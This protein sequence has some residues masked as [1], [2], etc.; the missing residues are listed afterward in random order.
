MQLVKLQI[1]NIYRRL[2]QI[3]ATGISEQ[4]SVKS[5]WSENAIQSQPGMEKPGRCVMQDNC[6][7][8]ITV[9]T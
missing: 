7:V 2:V 4:T 5:T 8:I 1:P 3:T 9:I 6:F